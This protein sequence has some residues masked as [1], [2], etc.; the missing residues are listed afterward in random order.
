MDDRTCNDYVGRIDESKHVPLPT[1]LARIVSA[2]PHQDIG[3]GGEMT[4]WRNLNTFCRSVADLDRPCATSSYSAA[5]V[6]WCSM[7]FS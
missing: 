1:T 3:N 4:T 6:L 5:M 7:S 2:K